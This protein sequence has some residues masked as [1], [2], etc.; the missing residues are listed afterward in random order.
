MYTRILFPTDGS[1]VC[2][3]ALRHALGLAKLCGAELHTLSAKE[4]FPYGTVSDLQPT[5]P[6]EF[7][8][9]QERTASQR[10]QA[11]MEAAQRAGVPCRASTVEA[12]HPWE[13]ICNYA[14]QQGCDLIVMA[15]HGR[16]GVAALLRGSETPKVLTHSAVPVLVVH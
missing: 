7:F 4:L 10:V 11:V 8:E 1:D 12:A 14:S 5:P 6:Q 3:K 16:H 15:S 9:D 2:A 13:A